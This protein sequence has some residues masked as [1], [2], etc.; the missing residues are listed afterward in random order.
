M[1]NIISLLGLIGIAI[2]L[3]AIY[4]E[5]SA[6]KSKRYVAVCDMNESVSCSLV[7]ISAYSKLGEVYLGL[8]KD[9]IF[10]LPNSYYGILFYI[11]ITIYPIYPFTIIPFREVLFFGASILSI[12]VCCLLAWILYF[13]LNNFCAICAT[14]YI[15]NMFILYQAFSELFY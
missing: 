14:T 7:L 3:Y 12:G 15:L 2:S 1:D 5:R 11:A 13:K 8:S 9:S 4:V 6:R 10:N